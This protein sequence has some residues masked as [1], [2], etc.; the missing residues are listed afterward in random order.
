M[1][2][3]LVGPASGPAR[4]RLGPALLIATSLIAVAMTVLI[5][6]PARAAGPAY[7]GPS[8]AA[9]GPAFFGPAPNPFPYCE[10]PT[11]FDPFPENISPIGRIDPDGSPNASVTTNGVRMEF[12]IT[13]EG[14]PGGQYPG[15]FPEGVDGGIGDQPK[16]VEMASDDAATITLS[17]PLFYT[18]WIFTDVD[19]ANEGFFVTPTWTDAANPGQVAVFGG[20]ANFDFAG[21]TATVAMF[22][23]TDTVAQD[24]EAIEGRVQVDVL[25]AVTGIGLLR[26]T[27]SGQSGFAIGGGCAPIGVAKELTAGPTWNGT[28][29][30]V[31]YT[32]RARNNLPSAATIG[33]D[34]VDALAA[35]ASGATSGDPVEILMESVTLSDLLTD[36]AFSD[37]TIVSN[38][39]TSGLVDVN[40]AFNGGSDTNLL[41][42]GVTIAPET[43]EEFVIVAQYTPETTGPL[44][45]A[46]SAQYE[47][48]NQ[49]TVGGV[50]SGV[51]V[52]DLSDDGSNP[53]PGVDNGAGTTNDPTV[54]TF[55]C[56][57][58]VAPTPTPTP[59]P[60]QPGPT[61]TPTP[62][63]PPVAP[64]P[65][66]T[67]TPPPATL[68]I[69]K[70]V[71]AGPAGAC[72]DFDGGTAGFGDAVP[73]RQGDTVTYCISVRNPSTITIDN[74][75][76][77]DPQAPADF[78]GAIGQ[79]A[80][81]G[82]EATVSFDLL[83]LGT[84]PL[85]NTATVTGDDPSGGQVPPVSDDAVIDR[86]V[87]QPA[88][89]LTNTVIAV[90]EPCSTATEGI[91]EF[92]LGV[93]NEAVTWC[94]TVTNTGDVAL[95]N[96]VFDDPTLSIAGLDLL[97][98]NDLTVLGVGDVIIFSVDGSIPAA[99]IDSI[100]SV[101]A[102]AADPM[103]SPIAGIPPV[104]DTN[105]ASTN[106]TALSISKTVIPGTDTP[107]EL[108]NDLAVV[109]LGDAVTYCFAVT[110][111]GGVSVVVTEV[112][113]AALGATI[114]IPAAS[115]TLL[116]GEAVTVWL[117]DTATRDLVNTA[118]VSGV[119]VDDAGVPFPDPPPLNPQDT[120]E[121]DT[122]SAD[123][124]MVKTNDA[125][126]VTADDQATFT[127]EIANAGPDPAQD[128]VAV[129]L[130]P[131]GLSF[132][133]P[134]A[135]DGWDCT[136]AARVLTCSKLAP[137][138][139]GESETL[140]Y[141][142]LVG[143]EAPLNEG[144]DNVARVGS[145]TTDPDLTNNEDTSTVVRR[146]FPPPVRRE[147]PPGP[148]TPAPVPIVPPIAVP[149]EPVVPLAMT[150]NESPLL[151]ALAIAMLSTGGVL[152]V[153]VRRRTSLGR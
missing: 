113:D 121:V 119:P 98:E 140:T 21:T 99:G 68:E 54:V 80:A 2:D 34:I 130:L 110:N 39:N 14:D 122:L 66:P 112:N 123:L 42:P 152:S 78:D 138:S 69:V 150:G 53:D 115:Q 81:N 26:D 15:F 48:L 23:D 40:A 31:T 46:C 16:G 96:V 67:P 148:F 90:N 142:V 8:T 65:T 49:A 109:N 89:A 104:D 136:V 10:N 1:T 128:V 146:V 94:F 3:L 29:F 125:T 139:A 84:T 19:R 13:A 143:A 86:S 75:T 102:E 12:E 95:T 114:P 18:Q 133:E 44:G 120:A 127:L 106:E 20:D 7:D 105:D 70:T 149:V 77:S 57:D 141:E 145:S 144:V 71:V 97:Q 4:R 137:L 132:V 50:A 59:T 111:T 88:I 79:L 52:V 76:V 107:C 151:V 55:D 33:A 38:T 124:S 103:G 35:A 32:I 153:G 47:L 126:A 87:P 101:V 30:D 62:T 116:P 56:P 131:I 25:G 17:E 117:S 85:T 83:I 51:D 41:D 108:S 92:L 64:T 24:S 134:I 43:E 63:S 73:V 36:A 118:E 100:A 72:P 22:N 9:T 6:P 37:I 61:P 82:G 60:S 27:G 93:T 74:V 11:Y 45:D 58:V 147:P 91:D 5:A 135:I 129:D 28:S